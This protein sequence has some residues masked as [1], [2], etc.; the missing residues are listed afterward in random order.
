MSVLCFR[1]NH[2]VAVESVNRS[3]DHMAARKLLA[4][5]PTLTPAQASA[6]DFDLKAF[7]GATR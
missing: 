2:L 7:E 1:R 5:A 4:R 3:A 6:D